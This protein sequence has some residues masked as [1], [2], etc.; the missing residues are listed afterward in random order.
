MVNILELINEF[1]VVDGGAVESKLQGVRF[2]KDTKHVARRPMLYNPGICI[3]ASGHK[4]AYLRD[5]T[6]RYDADNYLITSV[7]TPFDCESFPSRENPLLG[8]YIDI[9]MAKLNELISQMDLQYEVEHYNEDEFPLGIGPSPM[10]ED[11]KDAVIKLIK[12]LRT[13]REARIL[14]P[15]LVHEIYYRALCGKQAPVLYSIARGSGAFSQVARVINMMKGEYSKKFDVQQLADLAHM[16]V[17]TF[18]KAFK[19]ITADTPLQY[20]KKIRLAR[21]RDLIV[22]QKIK[23]YIAADA[24]GYESPSQFSRE[25]KRHF[26]Q[27]PAEM[28]RGEAL[29]VGSPERIVDRTPT[30]V[31][32]RP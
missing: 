16:S 6:F 18:H 31:S 28:L 17:S 19:N 13:D 29:H 21:A 26:G 10:D 27:S 24:V 5:Q 15:G 20:L 11:M 7:A 2:F 23:A 3:V 14:A 9:D 12:A 8:V 1:S 32:L 22:Q 25:F 30:Q 4:V